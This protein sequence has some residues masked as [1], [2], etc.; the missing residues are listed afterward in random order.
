[1]DWLLRE[2]QQLFCSHPA[3]KS[4]LR[5]KANRLYTECLLCGSNSP[6]VITG[7]KKRARKTTARILPPGEIIRPGT[8]TYARIED[9]KAEADDLIRWSEGQV[10][11]EAERRTVDVYV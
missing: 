4:V 10:E 11:D 7:T 6:G 1:M 5:V 8:R 3:K 9:R 2:L